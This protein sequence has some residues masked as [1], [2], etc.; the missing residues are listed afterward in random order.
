MQSCYSSIFPYWN[1]I[2]ILIW[3]LTA[4][5]RI[6]YCINIY[7]LYKLLQ[8]VFMLIDF[9]NESYINGRGRQCSDCI[10][11]D[12]NYPW[13]QCL[14]PLKLWA[15]I[16]SRRGVLEATLCDK[17]SQGLAA[18]RWFSGGT[19]DSSTNKTDS[20]NI[21][22]MLLKV[23]LNPITITLTPY[24]IGARITIIYECH[25]CHIAIIKRSRVF[26]M[27]EYIRECG[28]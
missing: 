4:R 21:T 17:V 19:A 28:F 20:L 9:E 24:S 6:Q 25:S 18:G 8:H 12:L 5:L 7:L 1:I 14:S 2:E 23:A 26:I 27:K 16:P 22:N 10:V 3:R 15:R 13:N 11:V